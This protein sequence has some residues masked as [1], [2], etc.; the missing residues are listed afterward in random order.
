MIFGLLLGVAHAWRLDDATWPIEADPIRWC[1]V[2]EGATGLP[3]GAPLEAARQAVA[4]FSATGLPFEEIPAGCAP[5]SGD[6]ILTFHFRAATPEDSPEPAG[7]ATPLDDALAPV[8]RGE[9]S[10]ARRLDYDFT[11]VG[12]DFALPAEIADPECQGRTDLVGLLAHQLGHAVGLA[13]SCEMDEACTDPAALDALMYWA[14]SPCTL[15][16]MTA[17]DVAGIEAMYFACADEAD[18]DEPSGWVRSEREPTAQGGCFS[19]SPVPPGLAGWAV[20][21]LSVRCARRR[22]Q[23]AGRL[24]A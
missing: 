8:V 7:W 15:R 13:H 14:G 2:D 4:M 18:P 1:V 21:V 10:F 22:S 3:E 20:A 9:C 5:V 17:D 16:E 19:A 23:T 6:G 24:S 12:T 11:T